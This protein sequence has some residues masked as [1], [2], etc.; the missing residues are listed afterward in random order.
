MCVK[1]DK[2]LN[3]VNTHYIIKVEEHDF[4]KGLVQ[5]V[6]RVMCPACKEKTF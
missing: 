1:C 6:E 3:W 5:T 4:N 2:D